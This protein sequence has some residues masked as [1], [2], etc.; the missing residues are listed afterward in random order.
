MADSD[1]DVIENSTLSGI[2]IRKTTIKNCVLRYVEIHT[3]KISNSALHHCKVLNST[4]ENSTAAD[5]KFH[6]I[7]F[8]K[9]K[10]DGC[11]SLHRLWHC[12]S[13]LR[14]SGR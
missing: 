9:L 5:T 7:K 13:F 8:T 3:S 4:I 10:M 12:Q 11:T 14:K 1:M 6:E 2:T